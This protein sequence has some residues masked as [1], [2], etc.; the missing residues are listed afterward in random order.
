MNTS[1]HHTGRGF[2]LI[3]V[4]IAVVVLSFGLLALAALQASLFRAGAEAKARSNA[5]AL[6]QSVVENAKTFAYLASPDPATY[7][8]AS[9]YAGLVTANLGTH[10]VGG[11]TYHTCRQVWRY[12]STVG[13]STFNGVAATATEKT[14]SPASVV[15]GAISMSGCTTST[16]AA[17]APVGGVAEFKE[18]R[19][20]V[21]WMGADAELKSVSLTDS[22]AAVA[23]ADAIQV[24]KQPVAASMGPQVWIEPPNKDNPQVVPIGIGG[25]QHAASS[26]PKPEQFV[27]DVSA[28]TLFSVQT[29][30]GNTGGAEVRLNRKLDVAAVS[31][32]CE[33]GTGTAFQS[34]ANVPAYQPTVWNGKQLAYM[35][36]LAAPVGTK[37]GRPLVSN[38]SPE[39]EALCTVCCRDHHESTNRSPRP[40]PYRAL[41][42]GETG[43]AEHWG[44][45]MQ[46]NSYQVGQGLFPAGTETSGLYVDACQLIRVNGLMRMA[47]DAQQNQLMVTPL[48][49]NLLGYRDASFITKYSGFVSGLIDGGIASLPSGYPGPLA[50][51]PQATQTHLE[52]YADLINPDTITLANGDVKKLVAFGLY[53]DYLSPDTLKAYACAKAKSNAGDCAGLGD[54]NSLEVLP[55]YAVNVANL[56]SWNSTRAGV[57][58]VE[59]ATYSNQGLLTSD[60]GRVT[61]GL[62]DWG[63]ASDPVLVGIDINN[64]NSGLAGT[65]PVDPDDAADANF[66]SDA[67]RF[68]KPGSNTGGSRNSLFIKVGASS[69]L[70]LSTIL[71]TSPAGGTQCTYANKTATTTCRFDSPAAQLTLGIANYTTSAK[72]KGSTVITNR[73]IC[74]PTQLR[75]SQPVVVDNGLVSE[76]ATL[77]LT[78]LAAVDYSL[79]IDI[80]N[81]SDTC[82]TGSAAMTP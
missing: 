18:V 24:V 75:V 28:A 43:G 23:P 62:R 49:D 55:F 4:M 76:S 67:Q 6:A 32:V 81:E 10:E 31:C 59:N 39:I 63:D 65:Q 66:V 12:Q 80:V 44:Y 2:S 53:I 82:P 79:T 5:T 60:G 34:S 8:V 54:R 48:A 57:A 78:G 69:T 72:V 22:I 77:T 7:P 46:G 61:A 17:G 21:A 70:T 71:V 29:F 42:A 3:E 41:T 25:D 30:T 33:Q 20:T 52:A 74:V 15:G 37:I 50:R 73:K 64:S 1:A 36:P 58:S 40:D 35:E 68:I 16:G 45:R 38:S 27:Q 14:Q 9:T 56:G 13:G 19:V 51:F 11:I 26:N 47:V